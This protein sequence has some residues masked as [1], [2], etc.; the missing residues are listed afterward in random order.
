MLEWEDIETQSQDN[1]LAAMTGWSI[2]NLLEDK[3]VLQAAKDEWI[4]T[5]EDHAHLDPLCTK[6][7]LDQEVQW[8]EKKLTELLNNHAKITRITAYSK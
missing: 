7:D 4:K 2:Q 1:Q 5:T 3:E 8:F 6:E